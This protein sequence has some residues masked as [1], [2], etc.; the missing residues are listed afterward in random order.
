M[1]QNTLKKFQ[2]CFA[3]SVCL[4]NALFCGIPSI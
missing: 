2:L 3:V 1:E 4:E